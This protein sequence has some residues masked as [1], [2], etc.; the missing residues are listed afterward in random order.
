MLR[1]R[2]STEQIAL[3]RVT[4]GARDVDIQSV[5]RT[6]WEAWVADQLSPPEGD[7]PVLAQYLKAQTLHIEYPVT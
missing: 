5:Q 1:D 2:P 4:F 7:D 6:G 3:N